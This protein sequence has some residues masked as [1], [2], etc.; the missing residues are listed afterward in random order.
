M[1]CN[2][3]NGSHDQDLLGDVIPEENRSTF[4]GNVVSLSELGA[5]VSPIIAGA[6]MKQFSINTPFYY[7]LILVLIAMVIQFVIRFKS[8]SIRKRP[9]A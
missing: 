8:K 2:P 1:Q 4:I 6:L 5:I 7:N 3:N 9:I